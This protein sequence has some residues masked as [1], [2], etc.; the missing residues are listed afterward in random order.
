MCLIITKLFI[1][2]D[3]FV[4][5]NFANLFGNS[6]EYNFNRNT[7]KNFMCTLICIYYRTNNII[8]NTTAVGNVRFKDF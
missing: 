3:I 6:F 1:Y 4:L 8:L 5:G 2:V 7:V